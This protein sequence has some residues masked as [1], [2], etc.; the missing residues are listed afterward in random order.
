[1]D[2]V[3]IMQRLASEADRNALE[4]M[5]RFGIPTDDRFES[6]LPLI[7]READD[8]RKYVRKAVSWAL[9]QIGKRNRALNRAAVRTAKEVARL[10]SPSARSIAS[11]ALRELRSDKVRERLRKRRARVRARR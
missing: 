11:D 6:L 7:V 8:E 5:A 9:R 3:E 4:G 10:D 2:F 1:V